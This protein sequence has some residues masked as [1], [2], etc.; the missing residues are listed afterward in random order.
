MFL[1]DVAVQHISGPKKSYVRVSRQQFV[2][3]YME[4]HIQLHKQFNRFLIK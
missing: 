3:S 4:R 2:G 1:W